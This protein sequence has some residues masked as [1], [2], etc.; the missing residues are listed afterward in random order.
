MNGYY[1]TT[2]FIGALGQNNIYP[3]IDNTSNN[4]NNYIYNTS[5]NLNDYTY[6]ISNNLNDY[7]YNVDLALKIVLQLMKIT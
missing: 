3:Y 2:N 1:A 7:T 4:L 6:N 5:N